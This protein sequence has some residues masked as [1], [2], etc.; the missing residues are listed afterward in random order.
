MKGKLGILVLALI[1]SGCAVS[2]PQT[3]THVEVSRHL[4]SPKVDKTTFSDYEGRAVIL[5]SI[6]VH[7]AP[8][9]TNFY[10]ISNDKQ[11]GYTFYYAPGSMQ[12]PVTSFY[13]Y[14]FQK[15]FEHLGLI[16]TATRPVKNA[17]EILIKILS[18][19]DQEAKI[20]VSLSRNGL[21]LMQ[22]ELQATQK[23]S[24]T[25]DKKELEKRQYD[26]IDHMVETILGDP[27]FKREF[28]SD[29]GSI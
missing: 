15:T 3:A 20:Q 11:V 10:Y 18:L 25:E 4:Y 28:F 5:G 1:I 23:L 22:K 7:E 16:V 26:Y 14:A 9:L 12:Q 8:N 13:W 21:L 27:D 2:I 24:P 29:K 17:P 6:E 19:T